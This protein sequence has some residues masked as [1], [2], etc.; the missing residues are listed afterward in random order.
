MQTWGHFSFCDANP[1]ACAAPLP[2]GN[3][4]PEVEEGLKSFAWVISPVL[5]CCHSQ[6]TA[7]QEKDQAFTA[8]L[9]IMLA[10]V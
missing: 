10:F 1:N 3:A 9:P 4:V 5:W 8:R 6:F 2:A 7:C